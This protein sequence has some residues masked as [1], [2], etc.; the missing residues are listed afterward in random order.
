M[1]NLKFAHK[2]DRKELHAIKEIPNA[3]QVM[4]KDMRDYVDIELKK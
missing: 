2:V 1:Q 4:F 3:L